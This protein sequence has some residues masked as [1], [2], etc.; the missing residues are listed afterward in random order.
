M[1]SYQ[2]LSYTK[3][4]YFAPFIKSNIHRKYRNNIVTVIFIHCG[5]IPFRLVRGITVKY[6]YLISMISPPSRNFLLFLGSWKNHQLWN[7]IPK[8]EWKDWTRILWGDNFW[9][10]NVDLNHV[11]SF[12][13]QI[14]SPKLGDFSTF[15]KT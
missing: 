2:T 4:V 11:R 13:F 8:K 5:E 1:V 10:E 15:Q 7:L 9:S 12:N 14:Q 3:N 6:C